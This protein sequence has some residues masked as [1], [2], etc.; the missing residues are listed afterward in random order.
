MSNL[1]E[2]LT[3]KVYLSSRQCQRRNQHKSTPV[4]YLDEYDEEDDD[5]GIIIERRTN[6]ASNGVKV[7]H[8]TSPK[9]SISHNGSRSTLKRNM[10]NEPNW[11]SLRAKENLDE[12][13]LLDQSNSYRRYRLL[14]AINSERA[15]D[16][17]RA[18]FESIVHQVDRIKLS[19]IA[20][21][22]FYLV[23]FHYQN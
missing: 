1:Y 14:S 7:K 13:D 8:E 16:E 17:S 23:R 11:T 4:D 12:F 19:I 15:R 21:V 6:V 10:S 22:S 9:P 5:N 18:Y 3:R 20:F 2:L